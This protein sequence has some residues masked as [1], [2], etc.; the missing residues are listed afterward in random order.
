MC[1]CVLRQSSQ[2]N[3]GKEVDG[4]ASVSGIITRKQSFK[5]RLESP[6]THVQYTHFSNQ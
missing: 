6:E 3:G 4:E 1:M 2:S 5:E